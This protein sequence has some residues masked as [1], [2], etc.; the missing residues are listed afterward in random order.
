M[1]TVRRF[2]FLLCDLD[3][4]LYPAHAGIMKVV[5]ERIGQFMV[6]HLDVPPEMAPS[7]R[8]LFRER[9]GTTMRGLILHYGIDPEH[10]LEFVHDIPLTDF[11]RP[12]PALSSMLGNID[13]TK[14]ILTNAS[15][16]HALRVLAILGVQHHF[17]QIMDVRD[18]HYHSKPHRY[19]YRRALQILQA[20]PE[21]C[22]LVED[23][24]RNLAPA[25]AMGMF[26]VLVHNPY[27]EA[28]DGTDVADIYVND[29]LE[30]ADKLQPIIAASKSARRQTLRLSRA[31]RKRSTSSAVL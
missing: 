12:N 7:L 1:D 6:N 29:I 13:L 5:G 8:R 4:T 17:A 22:I 16:E 15:R 30:L 18:F 11:I 27:V 2:R 31:L 10:Y 25:V 23:M 19:A 14:V 24:P 9:Y 26:G 21:E 3:D 20:Q 28:E